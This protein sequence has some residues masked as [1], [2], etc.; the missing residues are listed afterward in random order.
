MKWDLSGL[1]QRGSEGCAEL[2]TSFGFRL[3]PPFC[4]GTHIS[5]RNTDTSDTFPAFSPCNFK[6]TFRLFTS[7]YHGN[8]SFQERSRT[9]R[10]RQKL[11]SYLTIICPHSMVS[12]LRAPECGH[13]LPIQPRP[14]HREASVCTCYLTLCDIWFAKYFLKT[15]HPEVIIF[16]PWVFTN[17]LPL[18]RDRT[19]LSSW[20]CPKWNLE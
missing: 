11:F 4:L 8:T 18:R 9:D 7:P 13:M 2:Q 16:I 19:R 17:K 10:Y 15:M 20:R 1:Y 6:G 14:Y 12:E 5:Q 3:L